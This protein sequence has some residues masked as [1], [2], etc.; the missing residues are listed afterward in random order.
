MCYWGK[1]GK[2]S[3][4]SSFL[5]H[6]NGLGC[7]FKLQSPA[8][9]PLLGEIHYPW[10]L[11]GN[12]SSSHLQVEVAKMQILVFPGSL[13]ARVQAQDP[14]TANVTHFP[15]SVLRSGGVKRRLSRASF[16]QGWQ[17][18]PDQRRVSVPFGS[19]R[20]SEDGLGYYVDYLRAW[21][22]AL[23]KF[24]ALPNIVYR[25]YQLDGSCCLPLRP[26]MDT[27]PRSAC[28]GTTC[29]H[30][31]HMYTFSFFPSILLLPWK[32]LGT[33]SWNNRRGV[34]KENPFI[35]VPYHPHKNWQRRRSSILFWLR[36]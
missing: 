22:W 32:M 24:C 36:W 31:P 10:V 9:L 13:A 14:V 20:S 21:S 6:P 1:K 8:T 7:L 16:W 17:L 28:R 33:A 27:V 12:R 3:G 5:V 35:H 4:L 11:V 2:T 30:T 15:D 26:L 23:V 29:V 25:L 34:G 19:S 18:W